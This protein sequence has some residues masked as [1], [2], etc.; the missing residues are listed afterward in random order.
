[1]I[2]LLNLLREGATSKWNDTLYK[3]HRAL[4]AAPRYFITDET[5]KIILHDLLN[6]RSIKSELDYAG[7][8]NFG[9]FSAV[10][11]IPKIINVHDLKLNGK[12]VEQ[13]F[14]VKDDNG[15]YS[16][17]SFNPDNPSDYIENVNSKYVKTTAEQK[18]Y[19]ASALEA[20]ADRSKKRKQR[21][22]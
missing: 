8:V 20:R 15:K 21:G 3:Q 1:M 6:Q 11:H 13:D 4:K 19:I 10:N 14:W 16:R 12:V 7:R 22:Y 9:Y 18:E 2:K 5:G 17:S